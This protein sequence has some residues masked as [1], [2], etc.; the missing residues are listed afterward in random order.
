MALSTRKC[1]GCKDRFPADPMIKLPAGHFHSMDCATTYAQAKAQKA[2]E[3][4]LSKAKRQQQEARKADRKALAELNR[5]SVKWQH[6]Q[7]QK[8]FNKMRVLEELLWFK[9]RGQAPTCI[10]C[11][12]PLGGDQWCCGH[13][14]T[15]GAQGGL[16]YNPKNA[17]L[18][19][20]KRCNMGLSGDIYGTKH[21]HGYLQGL[22]NR[23]GE[24]EGQEIIDYC[25]THTDT[26][27]WNWEELECMRSQFNSKIRE[28]QFLLEH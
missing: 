22:K 6:K 10:S 12:N 14:K 7:T 16:R 4:Q 23:F 25:E 15:V 11:G 24:K 3:R 28:L 8:V 2:R 5:K 19:H 9:E 18:Q 21:T 17:Y 26:K 20:N 1:C 27:K 13:F